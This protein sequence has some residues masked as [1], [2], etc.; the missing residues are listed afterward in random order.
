MSDFSAPLQAFWSAAEAAEAQ[1]AIDNAE[2]LLSRAIFLGIDE[3]NVEAA[4][5]SYERFA[6]FLQ[7]Q[8]R[9]REAEQ[10]RRMSLIIKRRRTGD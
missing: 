1:G 6:D 2:D 9:I 7:R 8:S 10:A 3:G 4:I 5:E